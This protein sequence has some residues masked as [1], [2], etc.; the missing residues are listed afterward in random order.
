M[1]VV[2]GG[3]DARVRPCGG[4]IHRVGLAGDLV[5]AV[6]D[7]GSHPAVGR[8]DGVHQHRSIERS[9]EELYRMLDGVASDDSGLFNG[10]LQECGRISI[11]AIDAMT[12]LAV[13]LPTNGYDRNPG[14]PRKRPTSVAHLRCPGTREGHKLGRFYR[15]Y[16]LSLRP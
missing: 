2:P 13:K 7:V 10:K 14:S 9:H 15:L 12:V 4:Q 8:G 1:V 6:V 3:V 5:G 11:D 16:H